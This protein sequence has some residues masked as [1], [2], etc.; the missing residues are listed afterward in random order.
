MVKKIEF[1]NALRQILTN[2]PFTK[3]FTPA[4]NQRI[5]CIINSLLKSKLLYEFEF[6]KSPSAVKLINEK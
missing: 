3:C 2:A 6:L 5:F 4:I 1:K